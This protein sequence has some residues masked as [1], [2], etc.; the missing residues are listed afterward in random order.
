M[1][2]D[3]DL[4]DESE[5][6]AKEGRSRRTRFLDRLYK[7]GLASGLVYFGLHHLLGFGNATWLRPLE[8]SFVIGIPVLALVNESG[9]L[10]HHAE[11]RH[12]T[13]Q[14]NERLAAL[15]QLLSP[16]EKHEQ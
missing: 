15:E 3:I 13:K 11:M 6:Y 9:I 8:L 7:V 16:R 2:V 4:E 14:I 12:R 5:R 10:D 1:A